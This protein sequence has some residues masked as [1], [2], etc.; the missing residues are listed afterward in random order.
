MD[1]DVAIVLNAETQVCKADA[2]SRRD[3][4]SCSVVLELR[5]GDVVDV[6][7]ANEG[8]KLDFYG[9]DHGFSGFLV[10]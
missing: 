8:A 9:I 3:A 7:G 1:A 6:R 4:A 10:G 2:T 5:E